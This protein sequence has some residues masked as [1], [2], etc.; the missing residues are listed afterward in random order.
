MSCIIKFI[1]VKIAIFLMLYYIHRCHV[2]CGLWAFDYL[3][4][5]YIYIII[6]KEA[7]I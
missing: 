4:N 7:I 3:F 1:H 2:L 5:F 6:S